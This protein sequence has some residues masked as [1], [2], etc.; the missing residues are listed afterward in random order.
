MKLVSAGVAFI[1]QA[2]HWCTDCRIHGLWPSDQYC[3][4]DAFASI[5]PPLSDQLRKYWSVPCEEGQT[6]RLWQHEWTKHGS[7][8][9]MNETEYFSTGLRLFLKHEDI[10]CQGKN[11]RV[12]F[13]QNFCAVAC[14]ESSV[15]EI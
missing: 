13:D 7:C 11:G 1:L 10:I 9:G 14:P 6:E 3:S 2:Q 12:C 5:A 8:S 4:S 15:S